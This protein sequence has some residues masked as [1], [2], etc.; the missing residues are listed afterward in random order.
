[1]RQDYGVA[2]L[3]GSIS[4]TRTDSKRF[5]P[6]PEVVGGIDLCLVNVSRAVPELD[7]ESVDENVDESFIHNS[8]ESF[9]LQ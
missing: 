7:L 5:I 1:M 4:N 9:N 3:T 2:Q 8:H 6:V